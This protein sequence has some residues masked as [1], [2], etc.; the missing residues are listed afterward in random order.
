M[1]CRKKKITFI[2]LCSSQKSKSYG[3][4]F[5]YI[6]YVYLHVCVFVCVES[7]YI[8]KIQKQNTSLFKWLN[9]NHA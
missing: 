7:P 9:F 8:S 4:V 6:A 2:V 1:S 5:I 3:C